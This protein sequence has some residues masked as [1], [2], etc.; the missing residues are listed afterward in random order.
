MSDK[1][2]YN[3]NHFPYV[4]TAPTNHV[5][6]IGL[7][8]SSWFSTVSP[9][10]IQHPLP[11]DSTLMLYPISLL[12][13]STIYVDVIRL[14]QFLYLP[15]LGAAAFITG[16]LGLTAVNTVI[17]EGRW[18][19][20]FKGVFEVPISKMDLQWTWRWRRLQMWWNGRGYLDLEEPIELQP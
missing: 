17:L 11:F 20:G 9:I 18:A 15:R 5:Y 6:S 16:I 13:N 7:Q 14:G 10:I 4:P 8:R 3:L 1:I 12:D 2:I 19:D